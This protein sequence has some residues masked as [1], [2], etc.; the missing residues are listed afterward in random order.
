M[1]KMIHI[2][3]QPDPAHWHLNDG[4]VRPVSA[5]LPVLAYNAKGRKYIGRSAS[6]QLLSGNRNQ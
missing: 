2:R 4:T 1:F 6:M 5:T 3:W